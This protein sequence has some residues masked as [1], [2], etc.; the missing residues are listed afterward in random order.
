[1]NRTRIACAKRLIRYPTIEPLPLAQLGSH[2][3]GHHD[4]ASRTVVTG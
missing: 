1:M 4:H 2:G 3:S